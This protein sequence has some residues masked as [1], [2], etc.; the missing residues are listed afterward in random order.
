MTKEAN[1]QRIAVLTR[2]VYQEPE[3]RGEIELD[4]VPAIGDV[5]EFPEDGHVK[6]LTV[7]DI[8]T[9]E[10]PDDN[11]AFTTTIICEDEETDAHN[12]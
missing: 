9:L 5:V 4:H 7:V 8:Q 2:R 10:H 3:Y 6:S 1:G 11:E 12:Q